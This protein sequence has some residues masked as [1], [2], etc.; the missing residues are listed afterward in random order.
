MIN[1]LILKTTVRLKLV[2]VQN[3]MV[4]VG[5]IVNAIIIVIVECV[6]YALGVI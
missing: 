4:N 1:Q 2:M 5:K 6:N 3:V